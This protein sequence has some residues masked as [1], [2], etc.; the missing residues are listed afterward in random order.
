MDGSALIVQSIRAVLRQRQMTYK[1]LARALGLSEPTIK[2]D[3]SRRNFSLS[4][5]DDISAALGISLPELLQGTSNDAAPLT[6]LTRQQE[7]ALVRD[8][9][10]LLVAYLLANDWKQSEIVAA[11]HLDENRLIDVLLNLDRL[12]IID[13]RPPHRIKKLTARNF[14]WRRDGPVHQFFLS[15]VAPEFLDARFDAPSD[16]LHFVG[17]TLSAASMARM[18][19]SIA[20][21]VAEFD[22]LARRDCKLPLQVRDGCSILMALRKW[23]FSEFARLRRHGSVT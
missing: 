20:Q 12:R 21:L 7:Q 2:R 23:E 9:R 1:D 14:T 13:F 18:K 10:L 16:E 6:Q 5:L 8:P 15:R 19:L 17:G 4:R 11:F 22:E 3:F